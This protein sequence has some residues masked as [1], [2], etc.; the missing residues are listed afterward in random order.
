MSLQTLRRRVQKLE[1]VCA[2]KDQHV[3]VVFSGTSEADASAD[4]LIEEGHAE[5]VRL[6]KALRVIRVGWF[7]PAC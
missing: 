7:S 4:R 5:A 1:S 3:V 2:Q 6:G